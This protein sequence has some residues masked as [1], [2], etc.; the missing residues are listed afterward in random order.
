MELQF[1]GRCG[2]SSLVRFR[3]VALVSANTVLLVL[4]A[5]A[6]GTLTA[7]ASSSAAAKEKAPT[8]NAVFFASD[9]LRQDI[10][11]RYAAQG[12]M[13]TMAA[14]PQEGRLG[15]RQRAPHAGA[16]EHR[17]RLVHLA[18]GAW[19][20]VHG[21]T[22]NTFHI[23]GQPFAQPTAAVR[24]ERPPGGVDRPVRRARRAQGRPGRVGRRPQ[25]DDPGPDD[26]LPVVPLGSRRG[27]EL[28]R[29]PV[30]SCSTT[31]RSSARSGSSSTTPPALPARRP[32]RARRRPGDRLDRRLPVS[33]SPA[34]EMRLRV[35]DFGVDKYGLN[36]WIFDS[37]N[38]A[39]TN[40]DKVLFSKTKSAPKRSASSA[41]ASGRTSRSRSSVAR[42]TASPPGSSSRSRSSR[43][44]SPAS[45]Y[46]HL[47]QP[48][49]RDLAFVARRAGLHRRLRRGPGPEVP[50][51]D[52]GRLRHPRGRRRLRGDVR[53]AG[54]LLDDGPR[55]DARVRR[56]E[57]RAGPAPGRLCR[58][59][60]SSSTS[61]SG[62][63]H[64]SCRNGAPNPAFDDVDLNGVKDGR[65]AAREEFIRTAYQEADE[66]LTLAPRR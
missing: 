54:P 8:D 38:D 4:A 14:F 56:Q 28:H 60:T 3:F 65:V 36:A 1:P 39:T 52:R 49:D 21:S 29:Q 10:V 32:S 11:P 30:T 26:R 17:R 23:N 13:P 43:G 40:Y 34:K 41:R 2:V 16:A 20:G 63:S 66:V 61:S 53:R 59:P 57:V 27:D 46:S 25:R 22:N 12:V 47:G 24:P 64:R 48:C 44:T 19:P 50:D 18:T 42:S 58:R 33:F 45:A 62:S 5:P 55:A 35:L 7:A 51:L 15:D 31:S 9:G 6:A 37:T